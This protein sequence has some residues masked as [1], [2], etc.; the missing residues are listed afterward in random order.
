MQIKVRGDMFTEIDA[1]LLQEVQI[2]GKPFAVV[3][4]GAGQYVKGVYSRFFVV[5]TASIIKQI[6]D[7]RH[8]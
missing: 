2:D 5:S 7:I 8:E 1:K 4:L 3:D 6:E